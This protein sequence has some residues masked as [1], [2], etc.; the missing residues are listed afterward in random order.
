MTITLQC[1][2]QNSDWEV[3][4]GYARSEPWA[5]QPRHRGAHAGARACATG[6]QK[7]ELDTFVTSLRFTELP[8]GGTGAKGRKQIELDLGE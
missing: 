4:R 5:A 2:Y 7:C 6:Y 1:R 8:T 3:D